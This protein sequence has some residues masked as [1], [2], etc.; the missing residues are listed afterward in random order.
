MSLTAVIQSASSLAAGKTHESPL[1]W[2][3]GTLGQAIEGVM[4]GEST[5]LQKANAV[6]RLGNLYLKT[7]RAAELQR[8]NK[9]LAR[10]IA[11][12]ERCLA[13]LQ[14]QSASSRSAPSAANRKAAAVGG[15]GGMVKERRDWAPP[16]AGATQVQRSGLGASTDHSASEPTRHP[17]P[18]GAAVSAT[19]REPVLSFRG[20]NSSPAAVLTAGREVGLPGSS[21]RGHKGRSS[22]PPGTKRRR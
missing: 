3:L 20:T 22:P 6:A 16:D 19:D 9:A 4:A 15:R 12:L 21:G 17:A 18:L 11:E 13:G 7:Y 8:E 5:P 14:A 10:R 1:G 2:L